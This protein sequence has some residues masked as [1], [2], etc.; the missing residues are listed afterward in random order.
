M[1]VC[2]RCGAKAWTCRH[3]HDEDYR[4]QDERVYQAEMRLLRML[5][6]ASGAL[7]VI[8]GYFMVR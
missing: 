1:Q 4:L 3:V 2:D 8:A 7:L 5:F 6:C